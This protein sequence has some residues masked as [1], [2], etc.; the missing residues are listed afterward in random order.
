[1]NKVL[2]VKKKKGQGERKG[3]RRGG[4]GRGGERNSEITF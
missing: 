1:M 4:E 3:D 2:G